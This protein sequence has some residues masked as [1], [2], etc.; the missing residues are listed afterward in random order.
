MLTLLFQRKAT[1]IKD[2]TKMLLD[3]YDGDI[4][5]NVEELCK[6]KGQIIHQITLR[7]CVTKPCFY[8]DFILKSTC[9]QWYDKFSYPPPVIPFV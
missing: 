7:I 4:P 6:L 5:D 8:I 9:I 1:Y 3:K 2:T